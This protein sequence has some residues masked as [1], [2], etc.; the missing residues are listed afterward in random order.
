MLTARHHDPA[1]R[2][3]YGDGTHHCVR[4]NDSRALL[5]EASARQARDNAWLCAGDLL[6]A[7]CDA[8]LTADAEAVDEMVLDAEA[9]KAEPDLAPMPWERSYEPAPALILLPLVRRAVGVLRFEGARLGADDTETAWSL[10][11]AW[12][13]QSV[14]ESSYIRASWKALALALEAG[15]EASALDAALWLAEPG[16]AMD[17]AQERVAAARAA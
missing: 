7:P 8:A 16:K 14:F 10:A 4:C 15:D 9:A 17:R 12:R 3:T 13:A 2:A 11:V 5:T 1:L 6:C